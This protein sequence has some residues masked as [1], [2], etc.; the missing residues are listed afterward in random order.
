MK[1]ALRA[2]FPHTIPVLTGYL[3]M[4]AAFGILLQS[5]GYSALWALLMSVVIFAGSM[6][7]VAVNL[8]VAP[9]APLNAFL[10]TL[11]VNARHIFYGFSMLDKFRDYG[12]KKPYM[13][14]AMTD[15][16]FS[17]LYSIKAP[18][19]V[20]GKK[21]SLC[22]AALD[23]LY[24]I[25]G[26]VLGGLLGSAININPQG[27]EFVMTALFVAIY[28]DQVREKANRMP[29]VIGVVGT[30][31]CLLALGPD[32]FLIPAMVLMVICLTAVRKP[33]EVQVNE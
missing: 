27:I 24:W 13:I 32:R 33:L 28:V 19:D 12:R 21:F 1:R 8:L 14:F 15:E 9:F 2:A 7:F 4:G 23:H 6:Q 18:E 3:F 29:A 31:L 5:Q 10:M 25:S 17:I 11:M 20:D 16:T 22:I 30:A 26:C